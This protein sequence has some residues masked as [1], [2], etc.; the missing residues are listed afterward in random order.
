M[1]RRGRDRISRAVRRVVPPFL[2]ARTNWGLVLRVFLTNKL[3]VLLVTVFANWEGWRRLFSVDMAYEVLVRNYRFFDATWYVGIAAHGYEGLK[4]TAFFPL[5]PLMMRLFGDVLPV[6]LLAAGV[7]VSN[8]A[9]IGLLYGLARLARLDLDEPTARRAVWMLG[10]YPTSYYFSAAYTE[11]LFALFMV[12]SLYWMR[13][14]RWAAAGVAGGLAALTR[15]M[16]VLLAL[17]FVLEYWSSLREGGTNPRELLSWNGARRHLGSLLWVGVIGAGGLT[18]VAFLWW[19][20][21]EPFAFANTQSLY[22]RDSLMPW[23]TLYHGYVFGLRH[24][25]AL[26][27]P[28]TWNDIYFTTQLLFVTLVLVVLVASLGRIRWSYWVII[29]YSFLI[30]LFGPSTKGFVDYFISFSRYSLLILPL[31]LSLASL[32]RN[33]WLYRAYMAVSVGLLVVLLYEWSKHRWVA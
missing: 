8:L 33:R 32:L 9:F 28:L 21:G 26:N 27:L 31:F 23:S 16:G 7:L 20:F 5:F 18:Y 17:P 6:G 25:M 19:R 10:L 4:E 15:N 11:A 14:R 2:A 1:F 29:L 22:G 24:V 30:P 3:L 12:F 13:T